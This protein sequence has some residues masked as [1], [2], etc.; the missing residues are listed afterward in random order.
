MK[1][2]NKRISPPN[3][4]RG[5]NNLVRRASEKKVE[6][7]FIISPQLLSTKC[8]SAIDSLL[9]AIEKDDHEGFYA[10]LNL[11]DSLQDKSIQARSQ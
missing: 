2:I 10:K 8:T 5:S 11:S 1:S 3:S 7:P 9:L 6:N 4:L